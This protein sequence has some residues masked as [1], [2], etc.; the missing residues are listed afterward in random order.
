MA[1]TAEVMTTK[2]FRPSLRQHPVDRK[3]LHGLLRLGARCR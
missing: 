3:R 2:L 1:D